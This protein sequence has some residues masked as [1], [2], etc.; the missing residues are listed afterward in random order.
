MGKAAGPQARVPAADTD[1]RRP[2][3]RL[4]GRD[5]LTPPCRPAR[6]DTRHD[7]RPKR[8]PSL[9]K[10]V[11]FT[12]RRCYT[13]AD[14]ADR[15][16]GRL[17]RALRARRLCARRA[18]GAAARRRLHRP[19]R[20]GYPAAHV[21][22]AG[23]GRPR[24]S[25]CA[26]N[27][28]SRSAAS[29]SPRVGAA[30][31][32][33][34]IAARV[35]AA[36][37]RERRVPPGR[38][39]VDRPHAMRAAA[40][41][42]VVAL[43]LEGLEAL[44][45]P[46]H[47]GEARRHGPPRERCSMR[48]GSRRRRSAGVMRAIVSG[49]GLAGLAEPAR[50]GPRP[51]MPAFSPRSRA[52]R[53]RPRKAFVEDILAIAGISRVG[54]RSAGEIAER[55]LARAANRS[56]TCPTRRAPCSPATLPSPATRTPRRRR[57]GALARDAGLDLEPRHRRARGAHRLH[58]GARASTSRA[59]RF[60]ADF[61]RNLDYYTGFIFEA[62]R[63]APPRRQ[64]GRRRRPLRPP[65]ATPRRDRTRSRPSA[66]R[67]GSTA[68]REAAADEPIGAASILGG[69]L[70]GPP[71]GE[72]RGVLRP[73]RARPVARPR[74]RATIAARIAGVPDVEVLFLSASEIVS[75]ARAP[76]A[77]IS[78]S[79]AR[80]SSARASP[81]PT[82]AGRASD[83]ARL[84]PAPTSWSPCR[85]PG[86]TCAPWPISTRSRPTCAPGTAAK[87][88]VATKYVN[89]TRRFFAERGVA[90]YRIVES[91][92]AT[93]G[94]P[95]AGAA[96][97][98]RRHHDDGRDARRERPEGA[99]RRRDPALRGQSRRLRSGA[100]GRTRAGRRP[101]RADPDR[102]RGGGPHD[103]RGP[104]RAWTPT[105]RSR[106]PGFRPPR[107]FDATLPLGCAAV[108]IVLRCPQLSA[109]SGSS[110]RLSPPAPAT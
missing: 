38:H 92:G 50:T 73:G 91:L 58:G 110:R 54:G 43:A 79:P 26:P 82:R 49:R 5:G 39:R 100:L 15:R 12:A 70:E 22:D 66:A 46:A 31:R 23:R 24:S 48:S 19:L 90:D 85:R 105:G 10:T 18:A 28:R 13:T 104:R 63:S 27:T 107:R 108:E 81:M 80:T 8:S 1:D 59:F 21:R 32:A 102:R 41:A 37:R 40:D 36:D 2:R 11:A 9:R 4:R 14:D 75:T 78:A 53:R 29:I 60:A 35:P 71:A 51:S 86:S 99:R 55:F 76:A 20:R 33:T 72:R 84:R 67:S 88:R 56:G 16:E 68:S 64:A 3:T 7:T 77:P 62:A 94:A 103:A 61:A 95:A 25:A 52:R 109:F 89:L 96:E 106:P 69:A 44:G 45:A 30:R 98:H 101:H 17:D 34:A 65:A 74:G 57:S 97:T 83:A 87:M 47:D 42:E 6:Q 93:E